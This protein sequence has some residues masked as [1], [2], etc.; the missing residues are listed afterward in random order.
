MEPTLI[1]A[2]NTSAC[3]ASFLQSAAEPAAS[4]DWSIT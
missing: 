3:I 2:I 4:S 1:G